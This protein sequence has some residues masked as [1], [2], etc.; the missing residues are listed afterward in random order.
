V[1]ADPVIAVRR[2]IDC[3]NAGDVDALAALMT[4]DHELVV[5]DESPLRGRD[6]NVTAWRGYAD[7]YPFYVIAAHRIVE[8]AGAVAVLGHTTGSHLG[9]PDD[10]ERRLSLI[11]LADVVD[12]RLRS[13]RL[14]QDTPERRQQLGL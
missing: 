8:R 14:V 2:F 7:S 6:A 3:I 11:W 10:E 12:G 5:F 13:W 4:D 1:T 9:L